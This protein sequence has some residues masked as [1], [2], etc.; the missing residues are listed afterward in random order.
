[1]DGLLSELTLPSC[2]SVRI[3]LEDVIGL[4]AGMVRQPRE[5]LVLVGDQLTS[6]QMST[7]WQYGRITTAQISVNSSQSIGEAEFGSSP[8]R[9]SL[10]S[11]DSLP[12]LEASWGS[13][14]LLPSSWS[15]AGGLACSSRFD[16]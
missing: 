15:A 16:R 8:A 3:E 6:L 13:L 11:G 7:S 9:L 4:D 12:V 5:Q 2:A 10:S 14:G 1:M